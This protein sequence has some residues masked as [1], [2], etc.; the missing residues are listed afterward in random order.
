MSGRRGRRPAAR[1]ADLV[2]A[3]L[4]YAPVGASLSADGAAPQGWE[5]L[6]RSAPVGRWR[7]DLDAAAERLLTWEVHRR[8]GFL[9]EATHPR[10][11]VGAVVVLR[12]RRLPRPLRDR[13]AIPCRVVAVVDEPDRR[14]FAYGTLPGHPE[15]GEESFVV[16]ID[17]R[18][19]VRAELTAVSRPAWRLARALPGPA[20]LA[21]RL[22]AAAYL[23]ATRVRPARR[24][25]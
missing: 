21:Q 25:R 4:T 7:A 20:R 5:R 8:A 12:F 22:A 3:P 24:R 17:E 6:H 9:V 1:A 13:L 23:R 2:D 11:Q 14:G 19:H 18:G 10:A 16:M 15:A